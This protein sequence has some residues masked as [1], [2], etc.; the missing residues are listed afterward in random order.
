MKISIVTVCLNNAPTIRDALESLLA[1]DHAERVHIVV[2]GGSTDGTL[3][4][5]G[6][7]AGRIDRLIGGQDQG[8]CDAINKGIAEA[9]GDAVGILH[10]DDIYE[11]PGVLSTVAR[12]FAL[13]HEADIM[14][15]DQVL[16][17]MRAAGVAYTRICRLCFPGFR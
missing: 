11:S 12:A 14:F 15:G 13:A 7:H 1:E 6:E 4:I 10:A 5:L 9:T 16:V 2:D 3:D 8:V 17:R